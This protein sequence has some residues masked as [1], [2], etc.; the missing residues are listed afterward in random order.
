LDRFVELSWLALVVA[1]GGGCGPRVEP[2]RNGA[3][4]GDAGPAL[5]GHLG[6]DG[7]DE[8]D[9]GVDLLPA[10]D[11][12]PVTDAT[13][14][15]D[16]LPV[17]ALPPPVDVAPAT[18]ANRA[19]SGKPDTGAPDTGAPDSGPPD[20]PP[21]VPPR[22]CTA[23]AK[24]CVG[25]VPQ[26]CDASGA[27]QSAPACPFLCT[28]GACEGVC[29]PGSNQCV[30]GD[31]QICDAG[32]AWRST[33]TSTRQLLVNPAFDVDLNETGWTN[34]GFQVVYA[35]PSPGGGV[36]G[37]PDVAAQSLPNL[38]WFG[39][40]DSADD[41]L[42]QSIDI[43][44]GSSKLTFTF[45]YAVVTGKTGITEADTFD[46]SLLAGTQVISLA[47]LSNLNAT[48]TWTPVSVPLPATLAG[49]TVTLQLRGVTNT[50][51]TRT[52]SFY[53]D[54]LSFSVV[55]CP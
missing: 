31:L 7:G 14:P 17:D 19:D 29:M 18:D 20:V 55:T 16:A 4:K 43:P 1:A 39:G 15:V 47:H 3:A 38:G 30:G 10:I 11:T 28:A 44:A 35:A 52:T 6:E 34:P 27:W 48:D 23:P 25:L 42:S 13:L 51:V 12:S 45:F 53:I 8:L 40:L 5:R 49:Q 2:A 37:H 36:T 24:R 22:Q 26:T 41:R 21:D 46:A 54:T 32:G 9:A 50:N 33:G